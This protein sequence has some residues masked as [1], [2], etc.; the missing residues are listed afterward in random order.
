MTT[1]LA[2]RLAFFASR[3]PR[4]VRDRFA[5]TPN[6]ESCSPTPQRPARTI[7][8]QKAMNQRGSATGNEKHIQEKNA[9]GGWSTS[10]RRLIMSDVRER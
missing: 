7:K 8:F 4:R 10:M 9:Y 2:T 6:Y 1:S 3:P 5:D